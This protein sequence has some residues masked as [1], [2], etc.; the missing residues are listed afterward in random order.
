MLT[1][2]DR[3]PIT[4]FGAES[5]A[6]TTQFNDLRTPSSLGATEDE[7]Y[8]R[9]Q[10]ELKTLALLMPRVLIRDQDVVNHLMLQRMIRRNVCGIRHALEHRIIVLGIR[11]FAESFS[12]V[13][14]QAGEERAFPRLYV[15]AKESLTKIDSILKNERIS[16]VEVDRSAETDRFAENLEK[17]LAG[18]LL[19][20]SDKVLLQDAINRTRERFPERPRLHFGDMY[21]YLVGDKMQEPYG[22][23]VQCCRAAHS[24]VHPE[25]VT[26]APS[27]SDRDLRPRMVAHILNQ[28]GATINDPDRFFD[29]YPKRIFSDS[30]LEGMSFEDIRRLR[31]EGF[32][33]GYFDSARVLKEKVGMPDF[34]SA[35]ESYLRH[36]AEYL[37]LIGK[38]LSLELIDWQKAL[39][40]KQ[41]NID[42]KRRTAHAWGVPMAISAAF[43]IM[44][45]SM[46]PMAIGAGVAKGVKKYGDY[47]NAK[48]PD[49]LSKLLSG[50]SVTPPV[51]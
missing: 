39:L 23:V 49:S 50:L 34:E 43:A 33:H 31:R 36:L 45:W 32:D 19:C 7:A 29:L 15:R 41:I 30:V 47:W 48:R 24:L 44:T 40:K 9:V 38:E 27:A 13:N 1:E 8:R 17:V 11:S 18:E 51:K 26:F 20:D 46:V 4:S 2:L 14:E 25:F 5:F 6:W 10:V 21:Q 3:K 12:E 28:P 42:E 37:N 35:Y 22:E 16:V